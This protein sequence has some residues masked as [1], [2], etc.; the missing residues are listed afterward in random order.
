M[1]RH[2]YISPS[3]NWQ[4]VE[5][6]LAHDY[7]F[8]PH[9]AL[10]P[11]YPWL[12]LTSNHHGGKQWAAYLLLVFVPPTHMHTH[13]RNKQHLMGRIPRS[14]QWCVVFCFV[15]VCEGI[16]KPNEW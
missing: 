10:F 4:L 8:Q 6:R 7:I 11:F 1:P 15:C 3:T 2:T 14:I 16:H 9:A 12:G 13:T 5:D